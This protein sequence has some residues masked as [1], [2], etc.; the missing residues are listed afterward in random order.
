[1]NLSSPTHLARICVLAAAY[2]VAARLGLMFP[3]Y[4]SFITLIWLPS[5]IAVA[6]LLLSGRSLWPGIF[7]G[8]VLANLTMGM[9]WAAALG[10]GVGNTLGPLVTL[11]VLRRVGFHRRFSRKRDIILLSLG[12]FIGMLVS[13]SVG[14][15]ALSIA[16]TITEAHLTAWLTWW[17]GDALGVIIGAPLLFTFPRDQSFEA[18]ARRTEFGGWFLSM[19]FIIYA[20]FVLDADIAGDCW[21]LPFLAL[22]WTAWAALRFGPFGTSIGV[23]LLSFGA[24]YGVSAGTGPLDRED[25]VEG[26]T[27]LWLFMSTN[28]LLGWLITCLQTTTRRITETNVIFQRALDD[29]SLG[30]LLASPDRK[31]TFANSGFTRLTGYNQDEIMGKNCSLLQGAETNPETITRISHCLEN[32]EYYDGEILNYRKDGSSFWNGLV[33]S[34]THGRNGELTGF[35]SIQRDITKRKGVEERLENSLEFSHGLLTSMRE[36]LS[37]VDNEGVHIE[38]NPAFCDM[39]GFSREELIGVGPPHP[40]WPPEEMDAIN[41]A[42]EKTLQGAPKTFELTFK[43]KNGERFPVAVS[44]SSIRNQDGTIVRHLA[45]V[46]DITQQKQT[47]NL[48]G[49]ELEAMTLI[50]SS[51]KLPVVL[52]KLLVGLENQMPGALCSIL[53]LDSEGCRLRHGAAPSLPD[54]YNQLVDGLEIG[55][56]QGSCGTAAYANEQVIVSDITSDPLWTPYLDLA[57]KYDLHACWSTPIQGQNGTPIGTFAIYYRE[58][59]VPTT[60]E[61]ELIKRVTPMTGIAIER[62]ND[63]E[64]RRENEEKYRTLFENAGD[65]IFIVEKGM[66]IDCNLRAVEM[67]GCAAKSDMIGRRPQDFSPSHQPGGRESGEFGEEKIAAAIGGHPQFFEWLHHQLDGTLFPAEVTLNTVMLRGQMVVQGI[68]RDISR[69]KAAEAEI[70]ELNTNLE[71]RVE[72]RTEELQAANEEMEAFTYS[73]SHD[74]RAPLRAIHGFSHL[75][76]TN[77]TDQIDEKGQRL[78]EQ[79][80]NGAQRMGQLIDDLLEFSRVGRQEMKISPIDMEA[81]ASETFQF[82]SVREKE[83][84]FE[85]KVGHLPPAH[86][87]QPMIR[88]V[89]I[90]LITNAIKFTRD[91]EIALI[92]IDSTQDDEGIPVYFIRDNGA[93]F[94]MRFVEK[95]F[96]VF[97]RLHS[98]KEFE[99]TGVGLALVQRIIERHGG[100]IWAEGQ[101]DEGATFYFT[102]PTPNDFDI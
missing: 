21:R 80:N 64:E 95:L 72:K 63:E 44:P 92:E 38:V 22:P 27:I 74:L 7:I 3:Q 54:S 29:F 100:R 55:Q 1:M 5:G 59:R 18:S 87:T 31:V 11:F 41:A 48:L 91:R 85:F 84:Q 58:S 94:D 36:G 9:P 76:L 39:T 6:A 99:G 97:Q 49:W 83:R 75:V 71:R 43:R 34:P 98:V 45:T 51:E 102:L 53:L 13:S 24:A 32:G 15:L 2:F 101:V 14:V 93:G 46:Q 12:G 52:E 23:V 8:S 60:A 65:A 73:V 88:Q 81:L 61:L 57:R 96:G 4:G 50:A 82:L 40:Y 67:F 89:W 33:I 10:V 66:I 77:Y 42:M 47:E 69:H 90:N 16:G 17:V 26:G 19:A 37:V 28:A 62:K 78:L 70:R 79:I 56:G 20:L 30:V 25:P 68:V 35:F 86:G